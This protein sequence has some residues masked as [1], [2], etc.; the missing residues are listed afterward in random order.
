MKN[1][2]G[3]IQRIAKYCRS[4]IGGPRLY[5]G[6]Y[7]D[8]DNLRKVTSAQLLWLGIIAELVSRRQK[9][10][11][12]T[13][14]NLVTELNKCDVKAWLAACDI[15]D[16]LLVQ[17]TC[18]AKGPSLKQWETAVME[19]AGKAFN[20]MGS[21]LRLLRRELRG[22]FVD[23]DVP[24]F[25]TLHQVF[26]FPLRLNLELDDLEKVAL[27]KWLE[28]EMHVQAKPGLHD[29]ERD[30]ISEWFPKAREKDFLRHFEPH[31]GPGSVFEFDTEVPAEQKSLACKY[32]MLQ[33]DPFQVEFI[34]SK[35]LE[36]NIGHAMMQSALP[37]TS[38]DTYY[39]SYDQDKVNSLYRD[40]CEHSYTEWMCD[41]VFVAKSWKTYRTISKES[42]T[43][44][45]LQQGVRE[46]FDWWL[47]SRQSQLSEYYVP[48]EEAVSQYLC[49]EGSIDGFYATIDLSMASDSN[50]WALVQDWFAD[51]LLSDLLYA[52]RT[53]YAREAVTGS[54]YL[55]SKF[56]PMGSAVCFP[57]LS[58]TMAAICESQRRQY[59]ELHNLDDQE[60]NDSWPW[61]R[62]VGDDIICRYEIAGM[63]V[64]RLTELGFKCNTRK[65]FIRTDSRHVFRECCGVEY[66]D[67]QDVSV[68]KLPR[69][70]FQGFV[71]KP[72]PKESH[73]RK[74]SRNGL[75][76][77]PGL[78]GLANNLGDSGWRVPRWM[79]IYHLLSECN[80]PIVFSEDGSVGLKS[81]DANNRHLEH[82]FV[83]Q[84][85]RVFYRGWKVCTVPKN[86]TEIK[87][88][89]YDEEVGY[90]VLKRI[91]PSK[92]VVDR[93]DSS[94][95]FRANRWAN[96][97]SDWTGSSQLYE[98]LR[99]HRRRPHNLLDAEDSTSDTNKSI[100]S[101]LLFG[102]VDPESLGGQ[103]DTE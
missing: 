50:S 37:V 41:I 82:E 69:P 45:W 100:V 52:V 103:T 61:F 13:L 1:N 6:E 4:Q 2:K 75:S 98:W 76:R 51:S 59:I 39:W 99:T 3:K 73:G 32:L 29:P 55:Q 65:S 9:L 101:Y 46:A 28:A 25:R 36:S 102:L 71:W 66:L 19:A 12:F 16:D 10:R 77:V 53:P 8:G 43:R 20:L 15:A 70:N 93:T 62:I 92:M 24:T 26:A 35:G 74:I 67:G 34:R 54:I 18:D 11:E 95:Q 88:L 58:T 21:L 72:S 49:Q 87:D 14:V 23:E 78:V 89:V 83:D 79:I 80:L 60:S 7:L 47:K 86:T 27:D 31:H 63:V 57:I 42:V 96:S 48:G 84:F 22:W 90:Y 85:Q 30:I 97:Y 91:D 56:A 33:F 17:S 5:L 94:W 40:M 64:A 68:V 44:M 38:Y 81:S